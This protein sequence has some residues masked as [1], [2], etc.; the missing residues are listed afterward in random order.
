M[1]DKQKLTWRTVGVFV[2]DWILVLIRPD[3]GWPAAAIIIFVS[4]FAISAMAAKKIFF[5][6][7]NNKNLPGAPAQYGGYQEEQ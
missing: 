7:A 2:L 1:N 3:I 6:L 5:A 4:L